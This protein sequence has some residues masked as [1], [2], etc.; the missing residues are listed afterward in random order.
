M[1]SL[2][3]VFT[4]PK[5]RPEGIWRRHTVPL[6]LEIHHNSCGKSSARALRTCHWDVFTIRAKIADRRLNSSPRTFSGTLN[7]GDSSLDHTIYRPYTTLAYE[8]RFL[9]LE[10]IR[11]CTGAGCGQNQ[12]PVVDRVNQQ[13]IRLNMALAKA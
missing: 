8:Y 10:Q 9:F 13:P 3:P 1:V 11:M 12:V 2:E 5:W 7:C 6:F 4:S